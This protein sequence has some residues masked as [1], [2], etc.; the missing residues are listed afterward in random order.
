MTAHMPTYWTTHTSAH[1]STHMSTHKPTHMFTYMSTHMSTHMHTCLL[2][3]LHT[4]LRTCLYTHLQDIMGTGTC[5]SVQMSTHMSPTQRIERFLLEYIFPAI[6]TK[7]NFK[8]V[9]KP[10]KKVLFISPFADRGIYSIGHT[11]ARTQNHRLSE[12]F[13]TVRST[14]P[15]AGLYACPCTCLCT[16]TC[17]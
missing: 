5:L 15:N 11:R 10:V 8:L 2:T 17:M 7:V 6:Q 1:M 12:S 9:A 14:C 16:H 3:C 13:S 4:C